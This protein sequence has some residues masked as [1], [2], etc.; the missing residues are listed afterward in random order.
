VTADRA[1][2]RGL[3]VLAV[4]LY[5]G[6]LALPALVVV[7]R[8]LIDLG[9]ETTELRTLWG[10]SC[11][12]MGVI[13]VPGWL[14]NPLFLAAAV[15]TG[16]RR[17]SAGAWLAVFAVVSAIAG[18]IILLEIDMMQLQYPHVGYYVWLASIVTIAIAAFR[19][20]A[21]RRAHRFDGESRS[22]SGSRLT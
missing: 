8:P 13:V 6:S 7:E 14:A 16:L 12:V 21:V 18:P 15:T 10:F 9:K 19:G 22:S 20:I 5:L 1:W 11:L 4:G 2:H 3:V 17:Y